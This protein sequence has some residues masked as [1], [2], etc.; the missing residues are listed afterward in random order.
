MKGEDEYLFFVG[1]NE[2]RKWKG[3]KMHTWSSFST[4]PTGNEREDGVSQLLWG[5][6]EK[7]GGPENA[8]FDNA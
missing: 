3:Y 1:G 5:S 2:E 4:T 7:R 8:T 6:G